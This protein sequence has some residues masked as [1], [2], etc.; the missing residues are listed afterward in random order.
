MVVTDRPVLTARRGRRLTPMGLLGRGVSFAVGFALVVMMAP[1]EAAILPE[2]RS[3]VLYHSYE[4]GG[5]K[6][7]GPSVLVRKAY[8]DKFSFCLLYT[9]PSP[10]DA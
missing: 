2:D 7:D 10:R 8:K 9:S 6:V 4:G 3:D 5:L 1:A